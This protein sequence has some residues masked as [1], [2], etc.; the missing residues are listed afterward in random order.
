MGTHYIYLLYLFILALALYMSN[1]VIRYYI[2]EAPSQKTVA[3][4]AGWATWSGF[5]QAMFMLY[6]DW[7]I[8]FGLI[9]VCPAYAIVEGIPPKWLH[10]SILSILL[11]QLLYRTGCFRKKS[12][13]SE[14]ED[15]AEDELDEQALLGHG[16]EHLI[17]MLQELIE[18]SKQEDKW[19]DRIDTISTM[20]LSGYLWLLLYLV[21]HAAK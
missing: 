9:W 19:L 12:K 16:P 15:V 1:K 14:A 6:R 18:K 2:P 3:R 13:L 4:I 8:C 7:V 17:N 11:W 20:F 10:V 5:Y 21:Y